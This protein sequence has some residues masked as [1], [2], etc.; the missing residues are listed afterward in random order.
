M[1]TG[2][3][4]ADD[5]TSLSTPGSMT[6]TVR[7]SKELTKGLRDELQKLDLSR[8]KPQLEAIGLLFGT[9]EPASIHLE[10]FQ[11]VEVGEFG[12]TALVPCEHLHNVLGER[13]SEAKSS[14][15]QSSTLLG[16][17]VIRACDDTGPLDKDIDIH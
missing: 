16:W 3:G 14:S 6:C 13:I 11:P 4:L 7:L 1:N 17:Y 2:R 10:R 12:T 8:H 15:G 5:R 9:I